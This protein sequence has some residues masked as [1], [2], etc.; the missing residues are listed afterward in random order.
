MNV[1]GIV[2]NGDAAINPTKAFPWRIYIL[3]LV[4]IAAIALAP[5]GSVVIGSWIANS[6]GCRVDEGSVHPCVI[7]GKDYGNALYTMGVLGWLMIIT[8]PL[9]FFA[10][11]AWLI[12][13]LVH[14]SH[15]SRGQRET[16]R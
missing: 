11:M 6:H 10:F 3:L 12:V 9:G 13:L 15:W 4:A 2:V 5:V 16:P 7:G 1:L 8:L 14:R